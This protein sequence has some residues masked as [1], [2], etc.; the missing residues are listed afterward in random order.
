MTAHLSFPVM[1]APNPVPDDP[2][3]ISP[4]HLNI[5][6]SGNWLVDPSELAERLGVAASDLRRQMSCGQVTSR[7][8]VGS[9]EDDGRSRVT[10]RLPKKVWRGVFDQGGALIGEETW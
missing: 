6:P 2:T 9:G 7:I 1:C 10:I 3:E 5:D 8:E 4:V